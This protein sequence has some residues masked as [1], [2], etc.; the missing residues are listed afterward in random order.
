MFKVQ[1]DC[2]RRHTES[3]LLSRRNAG[4]GDNVA[5]TRG[6]TAAAANRAVWDSFMMNVGY[7]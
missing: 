7:V 1:G 5:V 2:S 3:F 4:P 6:S